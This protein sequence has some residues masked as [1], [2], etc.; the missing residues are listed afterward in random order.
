MAVALVQHGT[1]SSTASAVTV[2]ATVSATGTGNLL[3][4]I[5]QFS[6]AGTASGV[7]D[8]T[9]AFTQAGTL[10][11]SNTGTRVI[12]GW[13]LLSSTSGKTT[14]TATRTGI[15]D[16]DQKILFYF[17][18]SGFT[19]C[20]YDVGAELDSQTAVGTLITGAT[21]TTTGTGCVVASEINDVGTIASA[22]GTFTL[23][24]VSDYGNASAYKL[25]TTGVYI[26][27]WTSSA[28]AESFGA[29]T[30]SFKEAGGGGRTTHNTRPS[31]FGTEIGMAFGDPNI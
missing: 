19:S 22:G 29:I 6:N 2:A 28:S 8:G 16:T 15:A 27:T 7:S 17:E 23:G 20:A 21:N 12:T 26:P 3:V 13:Y 4:V 5:P 9:N 31:P 24:D 14:L 1:I 25:T 10:T 18:F 11:G 30:F